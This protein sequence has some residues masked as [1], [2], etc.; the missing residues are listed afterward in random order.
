M[1]IL[2]GYQENQDE[3]IRNVNTVYISG[4]QASSQGNYG[5]LT[6]PGTNYISR[7]GKDTIV[8]HL[9]LYD[10]S[11]LV[12]RELWLNVTADTFL[13]KSSGNGGYPDEIGVKLEQD[14]VYKLPVSNINQ[15]YLSG[16]G[17]AYWTA[18]A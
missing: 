12:C 11:S 3:N 6:V 5:I 2:G 9:K 18:F 16:N 17:T 7:S 15:F 8:G 13:T 1:T 4:T 10:G 14:T